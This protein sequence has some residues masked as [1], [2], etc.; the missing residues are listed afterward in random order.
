MK[1]LHTLNSLLF[2][3]NV[4]TFF[5]SSSCFMLYEFL[6]KRSFFAMLFFI[7]N[8]L[9]WMITRSIYRHRKQ[10]V[11]RLWKLTN[12]PYCSNISKEI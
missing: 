9:T 1:Q 6:S 4:S 11:T 12:A 8:L 5:F 2:W 3:S 7:V 10:T